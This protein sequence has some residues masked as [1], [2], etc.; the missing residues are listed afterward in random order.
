MAKTT[1]VAPTIETLRAEG[2]VAA[3]A[4]E[5]VHADL[6]DVQT[7]VARCR[8]IFDPNVGGRMDLPTP[9]LEEVLAAR[10]AWPAAEAE[11]ARL[12]L[13]ALRA[14]RRDAQARAAIK[15]AVDAEI[16]QLERAVFSRITAALRQVRPE[17]DRW[18]ELQERRQNEVAPPVDQIANRL[19]QALRTATPE[20]PALLD[21]WVAAGRERGLLID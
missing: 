10:A 7:T 2:A 12:Q 8:A 16:H 17:V 1:T 13:D 20:C 18:V 9:S 3:T 19:V 6:G 5:R 15:A 21:V 14:D 4:R 11:M